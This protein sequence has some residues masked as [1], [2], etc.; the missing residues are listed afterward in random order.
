MKKLISIIIPCYNVERYITRC[1]ESL[2]NQT[3]G[4]EKLEFIFV[5]DASTDHTLEILL[6]YEQ[7]YSNCFIVINNVENLGIGGA[8]NVALTYASG[9]YIGFVDSDDWV[10]LD[11]FEKL[12]NKAMKYDCDIVRCRSYRDTGNE[13]TEFCKNANFEDTLFQIENDEER[14][15]FIAANLLSGGVW[16]KL[17]RRE[18][19]FDNHIFFPERLA[20][21]DLFWDSLFYLYIKRA[22]IIEERLYHYFINYE[23]TVLNR[24]MKYHSDLLTV[25]YMKW[26]EYEKRGAFVKYKQAVE[27]DFINSYYFTSIKMLFLR[28]DKVP[29]EI[30][31]ELQ[32]TVHRFIPDYKQNIYI[33][34][35]TSP[36][37]QILLKLIEESVSAQELEQIAAS[38]REISEI[39]K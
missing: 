7:Q 3:M 13:K 9:S 14:S 35:Y 4:R 37:Y 26:E 17:Y 6:R 30:F 27:Y 28:F 21:E 18:I 22:Y 1:I 34:K 33:K 20:Y 12:Y 24:N 29:Y 31:L 11:M 10:E 25:N 8:R 38:Y 16:N 36:L 5:N 32:R 2:V 23:S 15:D 39:N 19:I